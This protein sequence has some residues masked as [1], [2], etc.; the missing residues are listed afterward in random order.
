MCTRVS[1][2]PRSRTSTSTST[3]EP[4]LPAL[5]VPAR[6]PAG[7]THDVE[8][9]IPPAPCARHVGQHLE[10]LV[11]GNAA[12]TEG[13]DVAREAVD[14]GL[15]LLLVCAEQPVPHDEDAPV[16]PVEVPTVA[17][18]VDPVRRGRV[19]NAF[20]RLEAV[21]CVGVD[22]ILIE[23]VDAPCRAD[24]RG[25]DPEQRQRT[26]RDKS[27]ERLRNRLAERRGQVVALAR[28]VHDVYRPHEA[29]LVHE[30]VVPVV[31]EV[32]AQHG[33][34]QRKRAGAEI[35]DEPAVPH[36]REGRPRCQ[37]RTDR[38]AT[39]H[40]RS[41]AGDAGDLA[42]RPRDSPTNLATACPA[43]GCVRG[44]PR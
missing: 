35:A 2:S 9:A 13:V 40:D 7:A 26:V 42:G 25:A 37:C 29:A 43:P 34:R 38:D 14:D 31:D 30:A 6:G 21:D 5:C 22:P 20:D 23:K 17:P 32:P 24:Q 1:V 8:D 19:E 12:G 28:M 10:V 39:A 11:G 36:P 15:V 41:H 44:A 16:V 4:C 3:F 33:R 18:V 27:A